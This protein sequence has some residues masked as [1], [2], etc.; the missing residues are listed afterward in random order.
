MGAAAAFVAFQLCVA[1]GLALTLGFYEPPPFIKYFTTAGVM[2]LFY[3]GGFAAWNLRGS[4]EKP[5][6]HLMALD[7]KPLW[8]FTGA[9]ALIWLQFVA[10]TWMKAMIPL[11]APMWADIPLANFEAAIFGQDAWRLLPAGNRSIEVLYLLWAPAVCLSYVA[12]YFRKSETREASLLAL[13]LTIGLLGTFGQFLLPSGGPVFFERLGHGDRFADLNVLYRTQY[14][15]DRL[16]EAYQGRYIAYATGISAFPSIHVA[17]TAW[18]A[19]AFR[20]WLAYLYLAVIFVGSI[21]LGWHYA[22]DGIAGAIGAA[23]CYGLAKV[24]L[25]VE[26]PS[27][28]WRNAKV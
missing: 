10:L 16:W 21:I 12:V 1:A 22:L 19:L 18:M 4:P 7:W 3:A 13:F 14:L 9:M 24:V 27:W 26:L 17:T 23:L 25:A 8:L 2:P 15:T 11:A 5:T 28:S 6:A 20:H